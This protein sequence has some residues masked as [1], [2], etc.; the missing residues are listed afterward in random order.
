M[1]T[2]GEW[3][4]FTFNEMKW[5]TLRCGRDIFGRGG[6]HRDV[7]ARS[8]YAE[9][10]K[11]SVKKGMQLPIGGIM[12][13][14]RLLFVPILMLHI[15]AGAQDIL[16][17][18]SIVKMVKSGLGESL[19]ISMVQ[20]Q[21]GKYSLTP[22]EV[23]KLKEAG[24]SEKILATMANKGAGTFADS[25]GS[26]KIELK[27]PVRLSVDETVSSKTAKAGDTFKLIVAEEVAINGHVVIAKGAPATGRIIV[28]EKKSL[29]T[30]NGKLEVAVDSAKAVDGHNI[31]VDGR[32]T[33][34]GGGVGFGRF[35]KEAE[36]ERGHLINAV[37]AAETEG[38]F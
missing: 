16:T 5:G 22:D 25:S 2:D 13:A 20:G 28:A 6:R 9:I 11:E 15:L 4:K 26:V 29:A 19:I 30:H 18:E 31:A 21:P 3:K 35:G 38:K 27:T 23:L 34:G 37:V 32:L 33:I 8:A 17:N 7:C 14:L 36:I 24:V 1:T 12:K 10:A